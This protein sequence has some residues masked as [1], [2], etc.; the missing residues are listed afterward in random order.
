ML[1]DVLGLSP[2]VR[3]Y[4]EG[5][6]KYFYWDNAPRLTGL[7]D[8]K[9]NLSLERNPF[10]LLKPLCES[11]RADDILAEFSSARAV[12]IFRDYRACVSSH[13]R[14]YQKY[15]DGLAYVREML[16][17]KVPCWKNENLNSHVLELLK[18]YRD[19]QLNLDT[20]YALYWLARNSLFDRI[21]DDKRVIFVSYESILARPN[22]VFNEIF[23]FLGIPFK[24][25]YMLIV[26]QPTSKPGMAPP[27][28]IDDVVLDHC[29]SMHQRLLQQASGQMS[30]NT[31]SSPGFVNQ[32]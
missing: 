10:T 32:F 31:I 26:G 28:K 20:A 18:S 29:K 19:R 21:S 1:S 8:V 7:E 25:K 9:K 5:A 14:Y 6:S 2:A 11:Q 4:G 30:K 17:L 16:D 13:V 15:H 12:W 23:D 3:N 24:Q 22:E 27:N